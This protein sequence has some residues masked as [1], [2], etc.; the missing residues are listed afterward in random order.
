MPQCF[1]PALNLFIKTP[2]MRGQQTVQV[3][4]V[5]FVVRESCSLIETW[6]IDQIISRNRNLVGIVACC[7][8]KLLVHFHAIL[9]SIALHALRSP[10]LRY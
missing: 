6:R 3:K 5:A 9:N 4:Y 10:R 8:L 7:L 2:H 1:N